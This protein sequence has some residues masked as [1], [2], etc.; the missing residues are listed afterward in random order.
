MAI[1]ILLVE[2]LKGLISVV[3]RPI[4]STNIVNG[5]DRIGNVNVSDVI[6]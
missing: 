2:G 5:I 1:L 4:R 6:H 3:A